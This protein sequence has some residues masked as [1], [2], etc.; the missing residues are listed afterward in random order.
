MELLAHVTGI[1]SVELLGF[2]L[3]GVA[4]GLSIA[5][6]AFRRMNPPRDR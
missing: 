4:T 3:A 2:F 1:E 5:Y 6:A